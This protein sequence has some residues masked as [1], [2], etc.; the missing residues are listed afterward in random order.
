VTYSFPKG[1]SG[2]EESAGIVRSSGRIACEAFRTSD[3]YIT[4]DP[5]FVEGS[6]I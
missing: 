1:A 5:K 3:S 4:F 2:V 6:F